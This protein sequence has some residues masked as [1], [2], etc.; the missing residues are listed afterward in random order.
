MDPGEQSTT[1]PDDWAARAT[2][3][4]EQGVE[5]V[6]YRSLRPVTMVVK[7]VV[8]GVLV[9]IVALFL[10]IAGSI[11]VI[12]LLTEDA[13]GGRVWVSDFVVGGIFAAAGAFLLVRSKPPKE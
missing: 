9:G 5:F 11:G 2:K 13:F 12:R 1:A 10:L 6:Q 3:L 8:I 7:G 4:V